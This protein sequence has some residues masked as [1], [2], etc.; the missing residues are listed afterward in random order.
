MQEMELD[1]IGKKRVNFKVLEMTEDIIVSSTE[2]DDGTIIKTTMT[3]GQVILE[4]NKTLILQPDGRT[5]KIQ[6]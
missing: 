1:L 3:A 6:E 2:Y 5:I 4:S